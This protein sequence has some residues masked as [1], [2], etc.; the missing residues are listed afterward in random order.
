MMDMR[1]VIALEKDCWVVHLMREISGFG[2]LGWHHDVTGLLVG[3][4]VH[5]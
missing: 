3:R 4:L 1:G 5:C 2:W